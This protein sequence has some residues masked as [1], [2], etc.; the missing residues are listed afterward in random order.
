MCTEFKAGFSNAEWSKLGNHTVTV[1][2]QVVH[3]GAGTETSLFTTRQQRMQE[4]QHTI[5]KL[6]LKR[7]GG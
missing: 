6:K 2:S 1:G 7:Q 4:L 3:A 5:S